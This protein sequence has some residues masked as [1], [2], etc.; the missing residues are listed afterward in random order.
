MSHGRQALVL[1]APA[2]LRHDPIPVFSTRIRRLPHPADTTRQPVNTVIVPAGHIPAPGDDSNPPEDPASGMA[3]A[4]LFCLTPAG[5]ATWLPGTLMSCTGKDYLYIT[6]PGP[7]IQGDPADAQQRIAWAT[8]LSARHRA[9]G[10]QLG[11]HRCWFRNLLPGLEAEH[12]FT[13]QARTDIWRL[14]TRTHQLLQAGALPGWIAEH[15]NN[16]G[17]EQWDFMNHLFEITHPSTERGYI[18]FIPAI[19]GQSWI[20]RRKRHFRGHVIRREEL[21][22]RTDLGPAPDLAQVIKDEFGLQPAWGAS[23]RR[24]RYNVM[25]E[26][27]ATGHVFSIMYDRCTTAQAGAPPLL[28]A[29]VEYIRSRT[30]RRTASQAEVISQLGHLTSW[31]RELLAR[32]RVASTENQLFKLTWLWL[33]TRQA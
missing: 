24:I 18:A 17:F 1:L 11:N 2:A 15:G 19:D 21:T 31:T 29:E 4:P 28:Q 30:L 7:Q 10:A 13:L 8:D 14:A 23:Y 27:L 33:C 5:R 20:I 32:E 26:S 25:L 6:L 16:G 22:E 9:H 12:K 3:M